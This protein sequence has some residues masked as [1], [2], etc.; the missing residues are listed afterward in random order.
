LVLQ[1]TNIRELDQ[2]ATIHALHVHPDLLNPFMLVR[3]FLHVP[4]SQVALEPD[5]KR[6][7]VITKW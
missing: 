7:W 1:I 6:P 3:L 2:S 5:G 4:Q